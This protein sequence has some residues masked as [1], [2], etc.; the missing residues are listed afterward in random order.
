MSAL[1]DFYCAARAIEP[2]GRQKSKGRA[3]PARFASRRAATRYRRTHF[4]HKQTDWWGRASTILR[5]CCALREK[6]TGL[7]QQ[8]QFEAEARQ[9]VN[10]GVPTAG[11]KLS[12]T[13]SIHKQIWTQRL[14]RLDVVDLS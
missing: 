9:C 1:E 14:R 5:T 3:Q 8:R 13:A 2:A 4:S 6:N 10:E 7:R 12:A 11:A